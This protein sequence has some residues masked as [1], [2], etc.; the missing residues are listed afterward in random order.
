MNTSK[1]V[2]SMVVCAG[3]FLTSCIREEAPNME[4][5]IESITIANA[6]NILQTEP[7]I[8]SNNITLRMKTFS[9][10]YKFAPEFKL[11]NGATIHPASGTVL[12]FSKP[13]TYTVTSQDGAWS[14]QY[15]VS[16][17]TDTKAFVTH[18]SFE[19]K[20]GVG[21]SGYHKFYE[22]LNDGQKL[23]DWSNGNDGF[24]FV[25]SGKGADAYPTLQVDDGYNGKGV[26]MITR[27]T[28]WLGSIFGN[29]IAA[30]NLFLGTF[31][32]NISNTLKST[33]FGIPYNYD[34][35]P[36]AITGYF[37]YTAGSTFSKKVASTL[38]KDTW[39]AY[40]I[41]FE[42]TSSN[43]Y[44]TGDHNFADARMVSVAKLKDKDRKE[45]NQWTKF[46]I[47]FEFVNGKT[48]DPNK[49]YMYTIV[50][51]SSIEG[52]KFNGAVGS[53]LDIDEIQIITE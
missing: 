50:F 8:E 49:E 33:R 48:F 14:K 51:T 15:T 16:F 34:K 5:D 23:F 41:L 3:A 24:S 36:K 29:P 46:E 52:D 38:T 6:Q 43:N 26:R 7:I 44:I 18:Y 35:A 30:G 19:N 31:S 32:L 39:N 37:K 40:A 2:S 45:T 25:A 47:P 21:S 20:E 17:I 1:F 12:D 13:Q 9:G 10:N 4:A 42:K 11:S 28:G 53:T 22:I 27:S